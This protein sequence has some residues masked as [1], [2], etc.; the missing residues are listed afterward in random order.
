MISTAGDPF[1]TDSEGSYGLLALESHLTFISDTAPQPMI[2]SMLA[3]SKRRQRYC[4]SCCAF[5]G[6]AARDIVTRYLRDVSGGAA[7]HSCSRCSSSARKIDITDADEPERPITEWYSLIQER[8]LAGVMPEELSEEEFVAFF[9]DPTI[10]WRPYAA[11]LPW[12]RRSET[13]KAGRTP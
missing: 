9:R 4:R 12:I 8:D 1:P 6:H 11:G 3:K 2:R 5:R 7:S 13:K 10:S